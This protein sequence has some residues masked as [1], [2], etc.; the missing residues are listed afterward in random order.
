MVCLRVW[1]CVDLVGFMDLA[2]LCCFVAVVGAGCFYVWHR[3]VFVVLVG[4][5]VLVVLVGWFW[6]CCLCS[7]L[8]MV[9]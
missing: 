4:S 5:W 2:T 8:W 9:Y 6:F 7:A 1:A 3:L